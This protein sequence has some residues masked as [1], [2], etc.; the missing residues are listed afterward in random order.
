VT[1]VNQAFDLSGVVSD[2]YQQV[3][4]LDLTALLGINVGGAKKLASTVRQCFIGETCPYGNAF[5]NGRQMYYGEGYAG[6]DDVVGHEMTHGVVDQYSELFYWGQSGAIN[7]SVAD[8][9]GE[10]VD[11]R[12]PSA[13]DTPTDWE[14]GE[15]LP[16]GAIRD[17]SSPT[18]FG[19]PD[20][21]TSALWDPDTA[22]YGD[23][24]GVHTNSG[25]GN[26][27]A[28]LI[29]QG[30]SFNGQTVTG[31]DGSDAGLTKTGRLY[32]DVI[33]SLSSGSDYADL[34][35]V[36]DQSCQ[37][38]LAAASP[39]FTA[40]DCT[41]VAK[42][43]S[44][45]QLRTTPTNAAQPPD[46]P[47]GCPT[48]TSRVVLLDSEAGTPTTTFTAV[49]GAWTRNSAAWGPNATSG[50]DSWFA[51]DL[52][53]VGSSRLVAAAGVALPAGQESYLWFQHWRLLDYD[54][55]GY[56]D[57]GTVEVD[58]LGDGAGPLD[59]SGL[60]WVN[61]PSNTLFAGSGN[62]AGGRPAFGGDS[63]GWVASRVDLSSYA[64]RTI[65]PQF[66]LNTDSSVEY[67][68]WWLDDVTVY[69]CSPAVTNTTSPTISG[70]PALGATLTAN[71]G[72]WTPAGVTFAYQWFRGATPIAGAT[73]ATYV[74]AEADG[75][76]ALTVQVTGSKTGLASATA[77][78]AAVNVPLA[79]MSP[80]TPTITGS[81]VVGRTLSADPGDWSPAGV[82]F[83]Y[84][85]LRGG[86]PISG[87]TGS[88]YR[89]QPADQGSLVTVRVT[90]TRTG[91]QSAAATSPVTG[92]VKGVLTAAR[93]TISGQAVV[94]HQ[95][96][97]RPGTWSPSGV[98]FHFQWFRG[99]SP[100]AGAT[101]RSY[102]LKGADRGSKMHVRVT[103]S[104]PGYVSRS[105]TSASTRP[106]V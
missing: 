4:G 67:I 78:S 85:W 99:S 94:G 95:L 37:D 106:V 68:G 65:A 10:I 58:D 96:V 81:A 6:A 70:S 47:S 104:K 8:I 26:K 16:I 88:T 75:G 21:M 74:V 61:G 38:L 17:L 84:Q 100:V 31:I 89:L 54:G 80:G 86:N 98:T 57:G 76:Q 73:S 42:A 24:G 63:L 62:P 7:E 33:Q 69:T 22:G 43:T 27:T 23:N 64:G 77:T 59:V 32:L 97:A 14:L 44:A 40:A 105:R 101:G 56:Y 46:A 35:R 11:H 87:A 15:D 30:G 3:G 102:T 45:T 34:A 9:M 1:D 93:P 72:S 49:G 36:L 79:A 51:R 83:G 28:Y 53:T 60:P 55:G 13:G 90:G 91:Y 71:P 82:T 12:H 18:S 52:P 103:G 2:F 92:P 19:Q 48:G 29:S 41:N 5:W 39:G 66:S 20:R 25:V 50:R